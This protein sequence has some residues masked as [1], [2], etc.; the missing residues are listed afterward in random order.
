MPNAA[1]ET[2]SARTSR[3][4]GH[5][6][7]WKQKEREKMPKKRVKKQNQVVKSFNA[8]KGSWE[9]GETLWKKGKDAFQRGFW[10]STIFC[11]RH[12]CLT[13]FTVATVLLLLLCVREFLCVCVCTKRGMPHDDDDDVDDDDLSVRTGIIIMSNW[14]CHLLQPV[15]DS[16]FVRW[17]QTPGTTFYGFLHILTPP[18]DRLV[19]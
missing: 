8:L 6:K 2:A 12:F 19:R 10:S 18:L 4:A 16:H 14:Y 7:L 17:S 13:L 1:R 5:E 9:G 11:L 15:S 3:F